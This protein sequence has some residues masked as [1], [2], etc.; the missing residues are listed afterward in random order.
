MK[1]IEKN[2]V[3]AGY[4]S[5]SLEGPNGLIIE[6]LSRTTGKNKSSFYHFFA[7]VTIFTDV[8]LDFH[9]KQVALL[10]EKES[11]CRN[12]EE[13]IS[14]LTEHRTDLL[15]N[16]QL[17]IYRSNTSFESCFSKSYEIALPS[18][19]PIWALVIGLTENSRLAEMVLRLS[20]ENFYLQITPE[21]LNPEWLYA[22]FDSIKKMVEGFKQGSMT[23]R[24][25]GSV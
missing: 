2:W 1:L 12:L 21:N 16:R 10:A 3:T 18:M 15:F 8:L 6:R 4:R 7:D 13:F 24:L 20:I 19:L 25:D 11:K 14:I 9:L 22:Y 23:P 17:R 5:F